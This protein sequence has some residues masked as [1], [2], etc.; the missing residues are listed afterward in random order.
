[1]PMLSWDRRQ[2]GIGRALRVLLMASA[3]T[4]GCGG[5]GASPVAPPPPPPPSPISVSVTPPSAAG[6]LGNTQ[7]FSAEVANATQTQGTLSGNGIAGGKAHAGM[8]ANH[9]QYTAP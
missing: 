2:R 6:P 4:L 1:M 8:N 3:W 5:G 9:R 7:N